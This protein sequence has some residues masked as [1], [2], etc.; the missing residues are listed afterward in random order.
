MSLLFWIVGGVLALGFGIWA[1][2]GYP[3]L[4]DRYRPSRSRRMGTWL[5]WLMERD[6]P[7]RP[8]RFHIDRPVV[9]KPKRSDQGKGESEPETTEGSLSE[10]HE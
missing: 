2:L 1:G 9:P 6:S 7:R 10:G 8:R 4:L 3:G 5:N